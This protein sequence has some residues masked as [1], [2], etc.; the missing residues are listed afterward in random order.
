MSRSVTLCISA[1]ECYAIVVVQFLQKAMIACCHRQCV[2]CSSSAKYELYFKSVNII[3]LRHT[4]LVN[5]SSRY[6]LQGLKT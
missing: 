1:C 2:V 4:K 6:L 3:P 5:K